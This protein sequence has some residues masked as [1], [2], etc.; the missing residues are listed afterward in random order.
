MKDKFKR[1]I[2]FFDKYY[3]L[4]MFP[5]AASVMKFNWHAMG[6][7][8]IIPHYVDFK[9][10][11]LSGFDPSVGSTGTPTFP[12][13]GYGWLFLITENKFLILIFQ[14][15]LAIFAA[16][17][18][19]RYL[20]QNNILKSKIIRILKLLLVVSLPWYA[21]NSLMWPYSV[22]TSLFLISFIL[23]IDYFSSENQKI[24]KLI[25]SGAL[26]GVMLN[27]RSDYYLMPIGLAIIIVLFRRF[28]F[29]AIKN[30]SVWLLS[31][32]FLLL[33]WSLYTHRATGHYLLTST[34]SGHV[35]FIGLGNLPGNKWGIEPH[36]GDPL[37]HSL[38]DEEFGKGHSSLVYDSDQFLKQKFREM[39]REDP[40][41]YA[42]K[43]IYSLRNMSSHGAY[44]GEFFESPQCHPNCWQNLTRG[45][46]IPTLVLEFLTEPTNYL[47]ES[48]LCDM[49][50][51]VLQVSSVLFGVAVV[52]FSFLLFPLTALVTFRRKNLFFI[53]FLSCIAYQGAINVFAYDMASYTAN[54]YFFHLINL[55]FG[56]ALL[57]E[58]V[59]RRV[60][61]SE[62]VA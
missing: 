6:M 23:L 53:L 20:E 42:R 15:T 49:F 27:F 47:A 34:N 50:I 11:I 51:A 35:F 54:M 10:I 45:K 16:W 7:Q 36:D 19:I 30:V 25:L 9:R 18:F 44:A 13:W 48:N 17:L 24:T 3:F 61:S 38:V 22:A 29:L 57:N 52:F 21:F 55:S 31:I 56:L 62:G 5:M 41:E 2:V 12:M 32:Y 26:F 1:I 59:L 39:V 60:I 40:W 14:N 33:P 8:G 43:I 58:Y 37:M 4:L 46:R 28:D